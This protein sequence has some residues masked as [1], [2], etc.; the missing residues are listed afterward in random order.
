MKQIVLIFSLCLG[1]F[2]TNAQDVYTSSGHTG[3]HKKAK[4]K[5]YD[6]DK[7]IIGGGFNAAFGGG[8]TE[9]GISPIVGYRF[10][11]NFSAG[12]GLG[13]QYYRVPTFQDQ[14]NNLQYVN[15]NMVYPSI[16]ARYFVY[17]NVFVTSSF[18]Y[19][20][21]NQKGLN[22]DNYGMPYSENV[23]VV[24][25]CLLIGGGFKQPLGGRVY[26]VIEL[27]YDVLQLPNSPYLNQPVIRIGFVAGI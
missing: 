5:G 26:G 9:L 20:F 3:Y 23:N 22:L 6:P 1:F 14:Y 18:E 2:M 16:W 15:E 19:D 21:I 10:T 8:A 25:P 7:L 27:M 13:Y 4:K 24:N 17:R 11:Q 12:V